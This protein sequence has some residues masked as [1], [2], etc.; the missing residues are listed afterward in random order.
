V[1][2]P[3]FSR[4]NKGLQVKASGG[5][6]YGHHGRRQRLEEMSDRTAPSRREEKSCNSGAYLPLAHSRPS[7]AA[8]VEK[9]DTS[10]QLRDWHSK[11]N[12]MN[13]VQA[14]SD[15]NQIYS[16]NVRLRASLASSP[17]DDV[18]AAGD[19]DFQADAVQVPHGLGPL[20][21]VRSRQ[22]SR[23][24]KGAGHAVRLN[25]VGGLISVEPHK[26]PNDFEGYVKGETRE[27]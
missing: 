14:Q 11:R 7:N 22:W 26:P 17:L 6:G 25:S 16:A 5:A 27:S 15:P 8:E 13:V 4:S 21:H 24:L 1:I 18:C 3:G 12:S 19:P 2:R 9:Q 20:V 10:R 23:G